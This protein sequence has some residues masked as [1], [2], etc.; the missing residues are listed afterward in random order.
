[1]REIHV[2]TSVHVGYFCEKWVSKCVA[3]KDRLKEV[4]VTEIVIWVEKVVTTYL[5]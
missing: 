3:I 1:M 4:T 2:G 5:F